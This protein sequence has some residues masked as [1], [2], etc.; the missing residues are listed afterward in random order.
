M[1]IRTRNNVRRPLLHHERETDHLVAFSE[2]SKV[3]AA[4]FK[5]I[6]I[7]TVVN[8]VAIEFSNADQIRQ[9]V[10]QPGCQ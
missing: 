2:G 1:T 9:V 6:A 10:G 4:M 3:P 5:A 8:T 7:K